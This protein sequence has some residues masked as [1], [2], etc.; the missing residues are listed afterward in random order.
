MKD[1]LL[2]GTALGRFSRLAAGGKTIGLWLIG[3]AF[4]A[5]V[6]FAIATAGKAAAWV[7]PYGRRSMGFQGVIFASW[8]QLGGVKLEHPRTVF[9]LVLVVQHRV[10]R[11]SIHPHLVDDLEPTLAQ[12]A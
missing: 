9:E 8:L 5:L 6:I 7:Q 11:L 3:A 2:P 10:V 12:A 4:V 1:V